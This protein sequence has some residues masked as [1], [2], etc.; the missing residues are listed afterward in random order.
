MH[1]YLRHLANYAR[2]VEAGSMKAASDL[3]GTAP[4]GLSE[5]VR[6]LENKIGAPLLVRHRDG[7]TPT[8]EGER[9]YAKAAG[10]VDLLQD[11]VGEDWADGLSGPCRL[12]IPG[13]VA[14]TRLS[15]A[16]E[17]LTRTHPA[18][19]ISVFAE[20]EVV[21]HSR[22]A[23]DYF[24]RFSP[25]SKEFPGLKAIWETE[26]NAVLVAGRSLVSKAQAQDTEYLAALTFIRHAGAKLTTRFLLTG[27]KETL[28]FQRSIMASQPFT[29]LTLAVGNL[30]VTTCLDVCAEDMIKRKELRHILRQRFEVPVV[31]RLLTPHMR[32]RPLDDAVIS[33]FEP[34]LAR[35]QG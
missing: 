35:R 30:G 3:L 8:L 4:S 33:A 12:S 22:F 2:I 23:R 15:A 26:V 5:S 17:T 16:I 21:D 34:V 25:K 27:P 24:L 19:E 31:A 29:S 13:E 1:G 20:D 32:R 18:L 10:I 7:V 6:I 14:N 11:A 9:V 28:S